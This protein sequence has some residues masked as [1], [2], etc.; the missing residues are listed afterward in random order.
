MKKLKSN[1]KCFILLCFILFSILLAIPSFIN[2]S[3]KTVHASNTDSLHDYTTYD[4]INN[5]DNKITYPSMTVHFIDVGQGNCILV[6][7]NH[8]NMLIDSGEN[9]YS[10]YVVTYLKKCGVNK[11]DYVIA[12]HAHDDHI[13]GMEK[14]IDNFQIDNFIMPKKTNTTSCYIDMLTKLTEHNISIISPIQLSS[15]NLGCGSFTILSPNIDSEELSI[16]NSSIMVKITDCN[17]SFLIGGDTEKSQEKLLVKQGIDL[18]A[19]V[20]LLNHHGSKTSNCKDFLQAVNPN[21][22]IIS[23]GE[24]NQYGLPSQDVLERLDKLSIPYFSTANCGTI[25]ISSDGN[26]MEFHYE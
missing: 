2:N 21:V 7:S 16:N 12:T 1:S 9:M 19:N 25:V 13:G 8:S 6:Q 17:N 4:S 5:I 18:S 22:A 23:V 26:S 3:N 15:Y 11:L 10:W 20:L 24:S 14:I